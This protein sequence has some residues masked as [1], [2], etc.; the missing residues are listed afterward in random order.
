MPTSLGLGVAVINGICELPEAVVTRPIPELGTVT[1]RLLHRRDREL[2]AAASG[3]AR[4]ILA[5]SAAGSPAPRR[6]SRAT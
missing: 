6:R 3:L 4:G 1:Y 2:G 5:L